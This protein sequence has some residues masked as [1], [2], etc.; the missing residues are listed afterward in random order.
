MKGNGVKIEDYGFVGDLETGA[1]VG[2]NGSVDWLCMPRFDAPAVFAALLGEEKS[3][4]WRIA[5]KEEAKGRQRYRP[6]TLVLETEFTCPGGRV[7]VIDFM[8]PRSDAP[9]LVRMVEGIEGEVTMD[10]KLVMRFGY[11]KILPWVRR[12]HGGLSAVAGPDALQLYSEAP[13][14]GEGLSTVSDFTVSAG[15]RVGFTLVWHPSH[16]DPPPP[17]DVEADL[18]ETEEYW[19]DWCGRFECEA[20]WKDQILRS[21]IT[22]K[23]LTY[24]PT[25]GV[26]AALTTSLPEK[27][28]GVRNW[29][30][31]YCWLRDATFTLMAFMEA[32][33]TEEAISW[34]DWLLR[35]VAGDPAELQIMYGPSGERTLPEFELPWLAGYEGSRPVRI[36]NAA[37]KQLQ[38]DVYGE[39]VDAMYQTRCKGIRPS[40]DAW[41]VENAL[42]EF[43]E[44]GWR[45]KDE[46]IWEVRGPRQHF[47]HSKIMAWVA[48][49]RAVKAVEKLKLDGPVERWKGHR[50]AL[51][52]EI[53]ARGYNE[54][55]GS[56]TQYYDSDALDASLLMV[57]LVGFL[58]AKDRR[59][60]STAAAIE[61]GLMVDG[62]VLR[63]LPQ[64]ARDALPHGE[65]T[66][67]PCSFWL[68]DNYVLMGRHDEARELF[69]RL[70]GVCSP[71]GLLA[72]EYDPRARRLLGNY[73]QAFS[74]VGLVNSAL[75][76]S[77]PKK[78][79]AKRQE[80]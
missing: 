49:D 10:G 34:R 65:G 67:L 13:T 53:L 16:E 12:H 33:Y 28:G 36:G 2:C 43:L 20:E 18:R 62:F 37:S 54:K 22:L 6:C 38:L 69:E 21:L 29:D 46:G 39:V 9:V 19:K 56:F 59:V 25:G 64:D 45:E 30:Y 66:F 27:I 76:L 40:A 8:P 47:T 51:R 52:R 75:N 41:R 77:D 11:G 4:F 55:I 58:P 23:A 71:L 7:K 42:L 79:A 73:P 61:R 72:E 32:G 68:V 50:E 1:L 60:V 5:P 35:A 48:F 70:L 26:V 15:Q 31:R 44:T 78:P 17:N 14:R 63:K 24:R 80:S 57:P 74:H 3:G